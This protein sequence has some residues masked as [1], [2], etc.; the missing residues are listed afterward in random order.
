MLD[1]GEVRL[2]RIGEEVVAVRGRVLEI[3]LE[4]AVVDAEVR[5]LQRDVRRRRALRA[6]EL[7]DA[8]DGVVVVE[9]RQ[10]A[11][12]RPERVGLADEP[13]GAGGV[14]GEDAGVLVLGRVEP[15]QDRVAR[16]LDEHRR[17]RRRGVHGVRVAVDRVAQHLLVRLELGGRVEAAAGVVEIDVAGDV[18]ASVVGRAK[19]VDDGGLAEG[20]I[21]FQEGGLGRAPARRRV[22][23]ERWSPW[24]DPNRGRSCQRRYHR[25]M[26]FTL[27]LTADESEALRTRAQL[28]G[29]SMQEVAR[30]AVRE[31]IDRASRRELLDEV[32]DEE[33][34][35][36]AGALR[37]LGE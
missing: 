26:A 30:A 8:V 19:L 10:E 35:R 12:L 3:A 24:S 23:R 20:R 31:Y 17:G 21:G 4:Q 15:A 16:L 13:Q 1:A 14:G 6:G 2:G 25:A 37:R 32:L 22:G 5:R 9:R 28:E 7:P 36:Y 18:E 34:P 11:V 27:R 33:L 29:R